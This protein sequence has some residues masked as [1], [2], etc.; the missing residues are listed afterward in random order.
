MANSKQVERE[1][2]N[3]ARE[4]T[5]DELE[6]VSGGEALSLNFTKIEFKYTAQSTGGEA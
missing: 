5:S 2:T 4:L 6:K 3:Q 1:P